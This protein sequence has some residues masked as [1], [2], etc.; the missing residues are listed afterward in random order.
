[1]FL[2][3]DF[4]PASPEC[5]SLTLG[6]S[7]ILPLSK[8]LCCIGF[9]LYTAVIILETYWCG[10]EGEKR[11]W[12]VLFTGLVSGVWEGFHPS[13]WD[14]AFFPLLPPTVCPACS[15]HNLFPWCPPLSVD[16]G[17]FPPLGEK[18]AGIGWNRA[19]FPSPSWGTVFCHVWYA[20]LWMYLAPQILEWLFTLSD[21]FSD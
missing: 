13:A 18:K 9:Q 6:L 12:V 20:P 3:P 21:L 5:F 17:V 14:P 7:F 11:A 10:V 16:C 4:S 1:M 2:V 15:V 19:E 8:G